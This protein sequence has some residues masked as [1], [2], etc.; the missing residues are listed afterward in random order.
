MKQM[1]LEES[2]VSRTASELLRLN[3][4][5]VVTEFGGLTVAAGA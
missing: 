2:R 5:Q 1:E 3:K 4:L